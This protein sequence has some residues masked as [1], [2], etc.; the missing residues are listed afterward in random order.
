[1]ET[2]MV[3]ERVLLGR[4]HRDAQG[5]NLNFKFRTGRVCAERSNLV[6]ISVGF[7]INT[8]FALFSLSLRKKLRK[9][10]LK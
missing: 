4:Q 1:M 8:L 9:T 3:N 2:E 10:K 7:K 6:Y 5:F